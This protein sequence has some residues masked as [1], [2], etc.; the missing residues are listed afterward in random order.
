VEIQQN[1]FIGGNMGYGTML[2]SIRVGKEMSLRDL[3]LRTDIDVA[4]LSRIERETINPPQNEELLDS[5]NSALE[6]DEKLSEQ[7]RDQSA[8]DNK[9]LPSDIALNFSTLKGFPIFLRTVSNKKI[10]AEQLEKLTDFIN[11]RY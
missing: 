2:R 10:T 5:I 11:E 4:Y 7:L 6:L 3:S 9:R 1:I 8:L